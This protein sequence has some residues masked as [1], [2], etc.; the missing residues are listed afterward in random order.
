MT[1][2]LKGKKILLIIGGGI[3]AYKCLDLIRLLK[4][5]QVE[6]KTILTEGGKNF[7]TPL[8]ITSLTQN[9]VYEN[10]FDSKNES[11]MDHISL[12]RWCD[13]ILVA[14]ATANSIAKFASGKADDLASTIILASNKQVVL[15]PAMNV[16][17]WIHNTTRENMSKLF[18]FGYLSIGP[19]TGD[20]AC[21]EFG[22]GK[23]S[24]PNDIFEYL[25]TYFEDRDIIK[26]KKLKAMVTAGP[27]REYLDPVRYLS[28][29]SSGK[30]GYAIA[31]SLAKFGIN[32]T[33]ISG[34]TELRT[35]EN[36]E[37]IKVET[38]KQML[39]EV[40]KL[41]PVNIAVCSAAV[42][43]YSLENY[44]KEKIKKENNDK[45]V[46]RLKK[47]PDILE[48]LANHNSLRPKLVVG[49]AAET[50]EI[51]K[52]AK[53]KLSKKHCD[54]IIANNVSNSSIGFNSDI[55]EV[56]IIYKDNKIEKLDR[57][58]KTF[59]AYEISKKIIANFY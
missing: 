31:E 40:K 55:N 25:K 29:L 42:S 37:I 34:P 50:H 6:I 35:P 13:I 17:M 28:N 30:Q 5:Q 36:V 24:S 19:I 12:S 51:I 41:L 33:L 46:L 23:M 58:S 56:S 39:S 11:E 21:G 57:N 44:S 16:R 3:S 32:T 27:T 2:F 8:S 26:N 48:Y 52:R 59:I 1:D 45:L 7:V 20:M 4:K 18:D 43:D 47:N 53:E 15:V 22:E 9:K 14:P 38:A 49:F 10:I 54:W